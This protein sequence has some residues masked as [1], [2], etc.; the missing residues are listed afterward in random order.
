MKFFFFLCTALASTI[1]T[2]LPRP[3]FNEEHLHFRKH[4]G[5]MVK[6]DTS[7]PP[8]NEARIVKYVEPLLKEAQIPY[9]VIDFGP[10]RQNII[11]RLKGSGELKPLLLLAHTD[12]VGTERQS[13][14]SEPHRV[15]EKEGYLIGRGVLDDLGMAVASLQVFLLLKKWN[16]SLKRDVILALT[17]DEESGGLG[18]RA[19]LD[20]R[21][22]LLN[23]EIAFNEG[24]GIEL[25]SDGHPELISLQVAEKTYQ[26]FILTAKGTTGHSSVPLAD[27]AIYRLSQALEKLSRFTPEARL[28]PVTREYFSRRAEF[29]PASM[30]KAMNRL[31]QAKGKL[32]KD[33]LAVIEKN[34]SYAATLRTTCT[35][36]MLSGGTRVNALPSEATATL[37]CRIL[38]DEKLE[39]VKNTLAKVIQDPHVTI[40][41]LKEF[42]QGGASPF[43]GEIPDAVEF[44][45]KKFLKGIPVVPALSKGA[46]D[47][48]FLRMRG[49]KAY[50][51]NP[52]AMKIEDTRRAHGID[53]RILI[54]SITPALELYYSLVTHLAAK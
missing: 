14:T 22:E 40:A 19:I 30:A 50:G 8:G 52:I 16:I 11:A 38:P 48:R 15:V 23:A 3:D 24:G 7:N 27:N 51:F 29:E 18:V 13:W 1:Q 46:S 25:G 12:V 17:G 10:N 45:S 49:I 6:L 33:A 26:D 35:A 47:S 4:L 32:P 21:P 5:E 53:E 44:I 20:R 39:E 9:E 54:S 37:N 34:P 43:E 36:T 31:T 2:T 28:I 41:P 42:D